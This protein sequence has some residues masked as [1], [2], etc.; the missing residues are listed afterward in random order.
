MLHLFDQNTVKSWCIITIIFPFEYIFKCNYICYGKAEL[1]A[2]IT[3]VFSVTW[4][5]RKHDLVLKYISSS[6]YYYYYGNS[7]FFPELLMNN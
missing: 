3:T 5:F 1:S 2:A 6:S 7:S 4:S